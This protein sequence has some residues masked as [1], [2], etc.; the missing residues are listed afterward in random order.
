M[1]SFIFPRSYIAGLT[2]S[3]AGATATFG[4]APGQCADSSN[5]VLIN[6]AA[7][8]SK[9]T[10]AWVAGNGGALD[11][12]VIAVSKWYHVHKIYRSD[13]GVDDIALSLNLSG[14]TLGGNI[15]SA[16]T[17]HRRL[18][19][20]LTDA[21]GYPI[22]FTQLGNVFVWN[23]PIVDVN[24]IGL[25]T[26]AVLFPLSVPPGVNIAARF[27]CFLI[28][29]AV[30]ALAL[31]TSPIIPAQ[32]IGVSDSSLYQP[33][34]STGGTG[35]FEVMTDTNSSVRAIASTAGSGNNFYITTR[36]YTDRRGQD[37]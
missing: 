37:I 17:L 23:T 26:T 6:Q 11:T 5:A 24:N 21:S 12:G 34:A 20:V 9:T 2:L 25:G 31:I 30:G 8:L 3:A 22:A 32:S 4:V 29:T 36:S 27:Q 1:T 19:S 10:A 15:P 18:G 16:Y 13:T 14:P 7:A 33:A 35:E 28:S